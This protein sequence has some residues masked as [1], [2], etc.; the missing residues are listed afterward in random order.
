MAAWAI[1]EN[2]GKVLFVQRSASKSRSLQWCLPGGSIHINE[3]PEDGC[4]REVR[5][6]VGLELEGIRLQTLMHGN[7]YFLCTLVN[8]DQPV[9]LKI[10]ECCR[11]R[12]VEPERIFELGQVMDARMIVSALRAS[13]FSVYYPSAIFNE[14]QLDSLSVR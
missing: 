5:E 9:Q 3:R 2:D 14:L 6:E 7:Y 10:T 13:G 1:I 11:Y 12:W 8:S 4:A